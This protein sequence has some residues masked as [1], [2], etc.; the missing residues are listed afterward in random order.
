MDTPTPIASDVSGLETL[1]QIALAEKR[2]ELEVRVIDEYQQA[3]GCFRLARTILATVPNKYTDVDQ[4]DREIPCNPPVKV[5]V[6]DSAI[7]WEVVRWDS[8]R[9]WVRP[10]WR[11][12]LCDQP[13]GLPPR[14]YDFRVL[15]PAYSVTG[16][17]EPG[18]SD[19]CP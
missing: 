3:H 7:D 14:A 4:D 15:G 12:H 6:E 10:V 16:E 13:A 8:E 19:T 11:V 9:R 18:G 17:C 5:I 1:L 2:E